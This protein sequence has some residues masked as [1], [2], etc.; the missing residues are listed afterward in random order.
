MTKTT[1]KSLDATIRLVWHMNER[2]FTNT[3]AKSRHCRRLNCLVQIRYL[4]YAITQF[5]RSHLCIEHCCSSLSHIICLR[6]VMDSWII[7]ATLLGRCS[8]GFCVCSWMLHK[9]NGRK[10]N[11]IKICFLSFFLSFAATD[12]RTVT[13]ICM[14]TDSLDIAQAT[15]WLHFVGHF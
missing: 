2:G 9:S 3:W 6:I 15:S 8:M 10:T 12:L 1:T 7:H 5:T 13:L 11:P 14:C 4:C